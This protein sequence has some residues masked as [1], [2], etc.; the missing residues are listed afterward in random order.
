[1]WSRE[2]LL[3]SLKALGLLRSPGVERA[4]RAVDQEAFLPDGLG[5]LAD[6]GMPLPSPSSLSGRPLASPPRPPPPWGARG[7][8]AAL[9]RAGGA[10]GPARGRLARAGLGAVDVREDPPEEPV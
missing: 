8:G 4:V 5:A 7:R 6:A 1:M 3:S 2:D 10:G 9:G